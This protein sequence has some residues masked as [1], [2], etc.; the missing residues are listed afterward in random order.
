MTLSVALQH[1]FGEFALDTAFEA[2]AGVTALFGHSGSGKTTVV[3][4][5]AGLL[6]P[7][8]GRVLAQGERL[9]D[10]E[11]GLWLPPHRRRVGYV[12]QDAR[13]LPHL[14][15]RQNL[16]YG[17]WFSRGPRRADFG[18][19]VEML[20]LGALLAR[21]PGGLS[22]GEKQ[23][24]ALGRAILSDPRLLLMDEP[25]AALDEGR[26]A[27]IL[28]Y[29]ERLRDELHLP[30]LYVSHSVAE[31]ARLATTVILL[32]AGRVV[33][34]GP[35]AQVL[36]SPAAAR[37]LGIREAGALLAAR[38]G[39]AEADGLVRL[40]SGG[41]PLWLPLTPALE[42]LPEGAPLRLR[43]LAQDVMLALAPPQGISALNVLPGRIEEILPGERDALVRLSV[44]GEALLA[45]ITLRSLRLL[46][47]A[48]GRRAYAVLKT[49]AVAPENVGGTGE[50]S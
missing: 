11:A 26:K 30:I 16:L 4:A 15:V 5:V 50:A 32:E 12:F 27:E 23:R 14:S 18:R 36:S 10:T 46:D 22:G 37:A 28:P 21:R 24:V 45:R 29:L 33:A 39:P 40:D 6:R 9:L 7:D 35:A 19:V 13:L 3:N 17:R 20:G 25:L 34:A 2:P 44:E 42:A 49:V 1:R 8:R 31:V 47:L 38:R 48:P 41:G 43:I